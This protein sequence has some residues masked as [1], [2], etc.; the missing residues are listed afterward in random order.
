MFESGRD[1][2]DGARD[3]RVDRV[4]SAARGRGVVRLVEDQ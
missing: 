3:L 2:A 4:A 1:I